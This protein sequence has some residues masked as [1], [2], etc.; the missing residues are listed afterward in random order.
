MR[1]RFS[2]STLA[3]DHQIVP[4]L[5]SAGKLSYSPDSPPE[6]DYYFQFSWVIPGIFS[7]YT[8]LRR[9]FWFG[10]PLTDSREVNTRKSGILFGVGDDA[11]YLAAHIA[12][13]GEK[14]FSA[15]A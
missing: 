13:T 10:G 11:A 6:R 15:A 3:G 9:H 4:W 7:P 14:R 12:L 5:A 1:R 8:R 2:T